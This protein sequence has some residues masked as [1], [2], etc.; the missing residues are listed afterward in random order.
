VALFHD[1]RGGDDADAASDEDGLGI[2][3]AEG[4]ELAE[5]AG[6]HGSDAVERQLGVNAEETLGRAGGEVFVGVEAQAALEFGERGGGHGE[7]DGEGVTAE[8]GEEIGAAFDGVEEMESVDGAAGAVSDT[9][10]NADDNGGLRGALDDARGEDAD[11]AAVPAFAVDDE[12]AV[13][14]EGVFGCEAFFDDG[15]G[16]GF[17]V[18]ALTVEAL[19]LGG[20]ICGAVRVARGEELDDF[21]CDVHASGGVDARCDAEGDVEAGDLFCGGIEG[22]GG[23]QSAEA[24][25]GG[26]AQFAQAEGGDDAVFALEGDSVCDGGDGGHFEKAGQSFFACARGV[27]AFEHG[28]GEFERDGC[29]AERFFRIRA[30]GLIGIEDGEGDGDGVI[31]LGKVVV[32]DDEVEA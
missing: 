14:G 15:E 6:E 29:A 19:E 9:V 16:G 25:A 8:A 13:G 21:G 17:G 5:P 22:G 18:A 4:F 32:G 12:E 24:S 30:A 3:V 26:A 11:D 10:F 7:A 27:A 2:A 20:Q 23:E 1:A 31:G 28:L